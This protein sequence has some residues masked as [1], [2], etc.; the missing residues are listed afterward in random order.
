MQSV[1]F[2]D[3]GGLWYLACMDRLTAAHI[4]SMLQRYEA[5]GQRTVVTREDLLHSAVL[6]PI[7]VAGDEPTVLLTQRTEI[8]ETHKGQVAFPG[9]TVDPGDRDRV[10]TA[11]REMQ[12]EVGIDA[13]DVEVCG[14]L[15]D[16]ATPTGYVIT[17]VVGLLHAEPQVRPNTDEVADVFSVP[18]AFFASPANAKQE[19]RFAGGQ[20]REIWIYRYGGRIIW[21]ATAA[22]LRQLLTVIMK[23]LPDRPTQTGRP[24]YTP[25]AGHT[26]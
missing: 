16:L 25:F 19:F 26:P 24:P 14:M 3:G 4:R 7:I 20:Q 21:G 23:P 6:V 15:D 17:P 18:L 5:S 8:V 11:L 10:H 2:A 12:E 22:V 1:D 9:G 13:S